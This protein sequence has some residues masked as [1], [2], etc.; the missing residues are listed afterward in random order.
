MPTRPAEIRWRKSSFSGANGQGNCVEVALG[1]KTLVRDS[2]NPAGPRLTIRP[3]AW[4][5]LVHTL[6]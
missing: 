3:A 1:D 6:R 5:A 2:K 4:A